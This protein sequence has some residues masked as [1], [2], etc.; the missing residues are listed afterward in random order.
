MQ[1]LIRYGFFIPLGADL[2]LNNFLFILLM[3]ATVCIAA[4]GNIINNICNFKFDSINLPKKIVNFNKVTEKNANH[5]FIIF[6]SIGVGLGFYISHQIGKPEFSSFF[7]IASALLYLYATFIKSILIIGNVIISAL[8]AF[9]IIIVGLFDLVPAITI[10]NQQNQSFIFGILL[11]YAFFIFYM[12]LIRE[13]IKDIKDI[14][15]DKNGNL[16]TLPIVL[17]RK[18]V[19]FIAFLMSVL[20]MFGSV[21]YTYIHLYNF[22]IAIV[23]S[24]VFV[25][26]PLLFF[27][28]KIWDASNKN[29]YIFLSKLLKIMMLLDMCSILLYTFVLTE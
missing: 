6:N 19:S 17:G 4:A 22:T 16:S 2:T 21:Y 26:A 28:I 12:N 3:T 23:F 10:L 9:S 8:I 27:S 13:I 7:I 5:L 18:R 14:D 1:A 25:L 29:D 11:N 20:A 24:L 15:A